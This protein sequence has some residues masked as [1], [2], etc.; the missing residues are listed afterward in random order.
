MEELV[1][2]EGELGQEKV[3]AEVMVKWQRT[4]RVN[5]RQVRQ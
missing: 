4:E 2:R 1:E 3:K 5:G